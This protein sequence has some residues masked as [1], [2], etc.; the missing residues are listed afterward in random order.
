LVN[1]LEL[2]AEK[3]F[4]DITND[5]KGLLT[6]VDNEVS[7][8]IGLVYDFTHNQIKR[9][10]GSFIVVKNDNF[11]EKLVNE[12]NNILTNVLDDIENLRN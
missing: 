1:D 4:N 2:E 10:D 9:S 12:I 7:E 6:M 5:D 3:L 8:L 11:S